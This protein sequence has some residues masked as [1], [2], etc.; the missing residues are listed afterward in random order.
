VAAATPGAAPTGGA[1]RWPVLAAR[2][3]AWGRDT[4]TRSAVAAREPARP[5][6]GSV[7]AARAAATTASAEAMTAGE[8][9]GAPI[10][11]A[12]KGV[13]RGWRSLGKGAAA[14]STCGRVRPTAAGQSRSGAAAGRGRRRPTTR[15]EGLA[16]KRG[17]AAGGR[18]LLGGRGWEGEKNWLY[19]MWE[20]LA[21]TRGWV[22]Y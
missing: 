10:V 18:R 5:G 21:L 6:P 8:S 16:A 4:P 7:E 9:G 2:S 1:G 12:M 17:I 20:T 14:G 13:R 11:G 22:M 19:T 3:A 15:V